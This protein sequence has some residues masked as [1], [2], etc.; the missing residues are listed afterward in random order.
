MVLG[1]YI[2]EWRAI[3]GCTISSLAQKAG[4][5][6]ALVSKYENGKRMPSEKHVELLAIAMEVPVTELRAKYLVDKIA[7]L[8]QYELRPQEILM[9]AE[10]RMEYLVSQKA[11]YEP[12]LSDGV[13]QK[14]LLIDELHKR[15]QA[16]KPLQGVQLQKMEEY[17]NTRYTFES[18]R[19]EGNTLTF[20]ETHLVVSEG[21]T[22]GGKNMVEHLEAVNH[23]EAIGWLKDMVRGNEDV[24]RRSVLDIHRLIL[25]SIDTDNAGV[26]RSV[27]VMIGGSEHKPPLPYLLDKLMEDYFVHYQ[28]QKQVLHPVI[29]A[30]EMH[31]RL[32]SI[33]PFIDGNGRT[34][35]LVMNFILLKSGYTIANLKGDYES[36]MAYYRALESVQVDNNPEPFYHLILDKV[37]ESLEEHLAMV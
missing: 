37:K 2:A 20:Q 4:V 26:Y 18:N 23:S 30:A 6:Q 31:E 1:T 16:T 36:R 19:I 35:R 21:L 34:S 29:L 24:T 12:K 11:L 10:D 3:N 27:P 32:V 15:W 33:H 17:F 13:L 9:A 5:D 28:R 14:L 22:I 7:G 8:L 25:K